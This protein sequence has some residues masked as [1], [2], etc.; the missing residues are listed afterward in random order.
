VDTLHSLD[1]YANKEYEAA[2]RECF[3]QLDAQ[4]S[5]IEG[6]NKIVQIAK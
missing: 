5:T 4:L 2:L 6:Q 3:I 1:Q